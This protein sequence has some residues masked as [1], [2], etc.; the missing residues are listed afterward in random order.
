MDNNPKVFLLYWISEKP[1]AT[2][3]G[4]AQ[5]QTPLG[6]RYLRAELYRGGGDPLEYAERN[7]RPGETFLNSVE[8]DSHG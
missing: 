6:P 2:V 4:V 7:T 3:S 1:Y 5:I 8:E